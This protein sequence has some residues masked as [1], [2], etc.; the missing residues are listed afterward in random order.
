[1]R[2][3]CLLPLAILAACNPPAADRYV[4][5]I[6]VKER[7]APLPPVASPDTEGA[8]WAPT[9]ANP[10]R[11][12]YGK[13]GE[14]PLFALACGG[15]VGAPELTYTRLAIADAN[16]KAIL[17]LIG[18]GHVARLKIDATR[19][20][21]YWLWQGSAP[22]GSEDFEVLTGARQ[23]EATVPGAGSLILNPSQ[24]PGDLITRCRALAPPAAR[25]SA[26]AEAGAGPP[27]PPGTTDTRELPP[28][29]AR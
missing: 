13:P 5:R 1:M 14:K 21:R 23:V 16:A 25:G 19:S 3:L 27:L 11:L 20:G 7:A 29:P 2:A 6:G 8:I 4:A 28:P 18:N 12:I 24:L 10:L 15:K 22:A 9:A 26:P 17:A